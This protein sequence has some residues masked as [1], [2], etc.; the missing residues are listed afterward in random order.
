MKKDETTWDSYELVFYLI[1]DCIEEY[2]LCSMTDRRRS[3]SITVAAPMVSGTADQAP[4]APK[5]TSPFDL[6]NGGEEKRTLTT[7]RLWRRK[8]PSLRQIL[9][10]VTSTS[11][12]HRRSHIAVG[13]IC[14]VLLFLI[15]ISSSSS[16]G[17]RYHLYPQADSSPFTTDTNAMESLESGARTPVVFPNGRSPLFINASSI[18]NANLNELNKQKDQR[19]LILTPLRDAVPYLAVYMT[20][21][22]RLTYPHHLIDLGFLISDT[23]DETLAHLSLGLDHIQSGPDPFRSVQI[24]EK[25]FGANV[26]MG[27]EDRHAF[28]GQAI[29]RKV[30]ARARNYLLMQCLQ[31]DHAW[32]LW[33]DVDIVQNPNSIIEDLMRHNKDVVVPNIW[34]HR[35]DIEGRCKSLAE[36]GKTNVIVDYNS[37]VDTDQ[38]RQLLRKLNSDPSKQ[39]VILLE[40]YPEYQTGRIYMAKMGDWRKDPM[41]EIHLDGIGGV[42][43][44]VRADVHRSGAN[45]PAYAFEHQCETEGF[46]RMANRMGY[47]VIGLPNYVVY[48]VDTDEKPKE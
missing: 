29:R 19:V 27:V 13:S 39:D 34:F 18:I 25:D 41:L 36:K 17:N 5:L 28:A 15:Y 21:L 7:S 31:A 32:V 37:W 24:V 14:L 8:R 40:G 23:K 1:E 45:F 16:F 26:G 12:L 20:L 48:H 11:P 44:M 9:R 2:E 38:T 4:P 47:D 22:N 3:A 10:Q 42:A 46:G 30:M 43:I 33:R 6:V 35:G